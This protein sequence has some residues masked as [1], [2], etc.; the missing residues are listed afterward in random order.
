[1]SSL[2]ELATKIYNHISGSHINELETGLKEVKQN[3]EFTF[4]NLQDIKATMDGEDN[5]FIAIKKDR[6][7]EIRIRKGTITDNGECVCVDVEE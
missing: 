2:K 4:K 3:K 1:M 7:K 5:W 6:R